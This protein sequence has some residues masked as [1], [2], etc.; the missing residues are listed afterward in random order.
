MTTSVEVRANHGWPVRVTLI[1]KASVGEATTEQVL[2]IAAG[3]TRT[4]CV[5]SHLDLLIHEIQPEEVEDFTKGVRP[6]VKQAVGEASGVA[7]SDEA[8]AEVVH[9]TV[10]GYIQ[11]IRAQDLNIGNDTA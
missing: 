9:R 5:H 8:E 2:I 3:E 11:L 6:G 7:A 1:H 10:T 4:L